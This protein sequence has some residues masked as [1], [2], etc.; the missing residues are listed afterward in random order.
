MLDASADHFLLIL[1]ELFVGH[2][3]LLAGLRCTDLALIVLLVNVVVGAE[4]IFLE[5]LS[6]SERRST[7]KI[8][9][10]SAF[11]IWQLAFHGRVP[12]VLDRVV[13]A[14]FQHLR[15]FSPLVV[16]NAVHEE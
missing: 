8:S 1:C 15:D 2:W 12:V 11:H 13:R 6:V 3:G 10:E 14:A 9:L 7:V 16:Y 4:I 5:V